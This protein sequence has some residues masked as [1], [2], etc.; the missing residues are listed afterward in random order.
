MKVICLYY[1]NSIKLENAQIKK[2]L[3]RKLAKILN[4]ARW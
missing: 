1:Q 3:T 4:I 2:K